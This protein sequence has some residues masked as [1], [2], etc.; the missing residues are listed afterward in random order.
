MTASE[1]QEAVQYVEARWSGR[2]WLQAPDLYPDFSHYPYDLMIRAARHMFHD[3]TAYQPGPS[4]IISRMRQFIMEDRADRQAS[5]DPAGLHP[6]SGCVW[7]I[8]D[9][10]P[11]T[12]L[13]TVQCSL[14][15]EMKVGR[16]TTETERLQDAAAA[17]PGAA[18]PF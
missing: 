16:Y 7:G 12:G 6:K 1:F 11:V 2:K 4:E 3:G 10:N 13:R 15:H 14:C 18:P 9:E 17:R 8:L 5:N